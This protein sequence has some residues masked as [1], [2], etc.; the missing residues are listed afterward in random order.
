MSLLLDFEPQRNSSADKMTNGDLSENSWSVPSFV[1]GFEA[2]RIQQG[3]DACFQAVVTGQPRPDVS[4]FKRDKPLP[5]SE[6]YEYNYDPKAGQI[7]LTIRDLGPGD[8]G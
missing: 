5:C 4:W 8:E 6:K 3:N 2:S 1:R 7:Q